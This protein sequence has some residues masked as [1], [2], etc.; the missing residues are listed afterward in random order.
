MKKIIFCSHS[1]P[2]RGSWESLSDTPEDRLKAIQNGAKHFTAYAFSEDPRQEH[3]VSF[4][5]ARLGCP[6]R[7]AC[8]EQSAN[9]YWQN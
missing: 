5:Q 8:R 4:V 6:E 9:N 2:P 1:D 3:A 7:R